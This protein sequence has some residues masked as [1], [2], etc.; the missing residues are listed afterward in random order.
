MLTI[1]ITHHCEQLFMSLHDEDL[2]DPYKSLNVSL[3]KFRGLWSLPCPERLWGP[4][5]ILS[6]GYRG[7]FPW[8]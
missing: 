6:N 8:G 1:H 3:V 7:L 2:H 5:S 4:P